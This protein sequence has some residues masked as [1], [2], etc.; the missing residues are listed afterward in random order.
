M[1]FKERSPQSFPEYKRTALKSAFGFKENHQ[2]NLQFEPWCHI[3]RYFF[4]QQS[5]NPKTM[6]LNAHQGY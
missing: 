6:N 5:K 3:H 2:Y 1:C 4:I